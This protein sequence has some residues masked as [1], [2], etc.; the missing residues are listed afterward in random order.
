MVKRLKEEGEG[1][2]KYIGDARGSGLM[3]G[4]EFVKDKQTRKPYPEMAGKVRLEAY[5]RGVIV[6]K[7]GHYGNVIRFLPP[8]VLTKELADNGIDVFLETCKALE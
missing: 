3:I 1:E 2:R 6:E 4:V 5:K 7:G 8:L